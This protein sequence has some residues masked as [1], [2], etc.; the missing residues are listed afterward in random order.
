MRE[1]KLYKRQ[2]TNAVHANDNGDMLRLKPQQ[3]AQLLLW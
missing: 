2:K 1:F 3:E